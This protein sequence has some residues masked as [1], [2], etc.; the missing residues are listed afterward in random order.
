[1]KTKNE[2]DKL[3]AALELNEVRC[4]GQHSYD[5]LNNIYDNISTGFYQFESPDILLS[6]NNKTILIEAFE[7]NA[8]QSNKKGSKINSEIGQIENDLKKSVVDKYD[9]DL[10]I[11]NYSIEAN[12]SL[13]NY[14]NNL[15]KNFNNHAN[16]E[17]IKQYENHYFKYEIELTK[18]I[19]LI[20]ISSSAF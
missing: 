4:Y 19:S 17:K 6:L 9:G 15:F 5:E 11:K 1:M 18:K 13:E 16:E 7:F 12:L 14:K 8:T 10:M 20:K 3:I 2:L